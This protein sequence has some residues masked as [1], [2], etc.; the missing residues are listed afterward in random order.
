HIS[1]TDVLMLVAWRLGWPLLTLRSAMSATTT[2]VYSRCTRA[3]LRERVRFRRLHSRPPFSS[4]VEVH[5]KTKESSPMKRLS[6]VLSLAASMW[7]CGSSG[8]TTPAAVVA[9]TVPTFTVSGVISAV[10]PTSSAP[11]E[12]VH[13]F[14]NGHR[15]TTDDQGFYSIAGVEPNSFANA[16]TATKPGYKVETTSLTISGDARVDMQLVRT[17][18]FTL[19]GVVSE[20]TSAGLVGVEGVRVE[21]L[22]MPCAEK[23]AGCLGVG[24]PI[25]IFQSA[26]TGKN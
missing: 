8:P 4:G 18:I 17:A 15:A 1:D 19:S 22:S 24:D 25:C 16:V 23:V 26:T 11:L 10:T 2:R 21:V 9:P 5:A 20:V 14:I 7:A 3:C 6:L 13:M 12:G